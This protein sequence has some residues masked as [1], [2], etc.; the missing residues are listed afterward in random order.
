MP[1]ST[2][3]T[4]QLLIAMPALRDPNFAR[5]VTFLCQHGEDG[6]MGLMINRLSEYRL[7]DVLAQMNMHS[8][9]P[10]VVDAPVLIGGPVQPERGFVL[11]TPNGDW[12]SSFRISERVSVTTSRDILVAIA[13][14][15]GPR[16]AVVALGYSG[17]S[18]G[19]LEQELVENHWLTAPA[20][21]RLLFETPLDQRWEAAANLVGVNLFQMA[22]YAGHA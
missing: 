20:S 21:E 7:G 11:H 10:D 5:G 17:W 13:A 14:G 12:E 4:N 2:P 22:S 6:A 16:H 15:N 8:E 1:E 18:P 3:L 9:I 19:Q